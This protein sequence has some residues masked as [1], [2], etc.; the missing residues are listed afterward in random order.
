ME[1]QLIVYKVAARHEAKLILSDNRFRPPKWLVN[2]V[3]SGDLPDDALLIWK[4]TVEKFGPK[5]NFG[6]G[7]A[8]WRNKMRKEGHALDQKYLKGGT[9]LGFG[10][11]KI[12]TGDQIEDW[13][14]E[15]LNSEGLINNATR[16]AAEWQL[17]ISSIASAIED[18][19]QRI[20]THEAGLEKGSRVNQRIKWL[21]QAKKDLETGQKSLDEAEKAVAELAK[22]AQRHDT[23]KTPVVAFEKDFQKSLILA[24]KDLQKKDVLE[25]ARAALARFEAELETAEETPIEEAPPTQRSPMRFEAGAGDWI[26]NALKK[27]WGIVA[28]AFQ[29]IRE[30]AGDLKGETKTLNKMLDKAGARA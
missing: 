12:K 20:T 7:V 14:R 29:T 9:G 2:G 3:D 21:A 24:A 16:S 28:G 15:R 27:A 8:Y 11:W 10:P 19:Q 5:F 22:A 18:A 1:P 4:R 25:A 26:L 30:W 17:E 23:H 13:V 6:A